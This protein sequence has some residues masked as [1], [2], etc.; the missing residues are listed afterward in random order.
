MLLKP[1]YTRSFVRW[2]RCGSVLP[3]TLTTSEEEVTAGSA[4]ASSDGYWHNLVE[5]SGPFPEIDVAKLLRQAFR[6]YTKQDA[7]T[8]LPEQVS[9]VLLRYYKSIGDINRLKFFQTVCTE[10]GID[11]S[12]ANVAMKSWNNRVSRSTAA[13]YETILSNAGLVCDAFRP[14]YTHMWQPLSQQEDGLEFLVRLRGD[15]LEVIQKQPSQASALRALS[16][17]LR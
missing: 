16:E 4:Q 11:V 8:V 5:A 15:L 2:A 7:S 13:D 1:Q 3:R 12:K 17:D 10:L 6:V 14:L 9:A